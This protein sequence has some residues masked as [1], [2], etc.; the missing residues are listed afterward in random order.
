MSVALADPLIAKYDVPGPR[1]TS[2]PTVPYWDTMPDARQWVE[3]IAE[4]LHAGPAH[5]AA[6]Y[7][8]IPFCRALCT[9]CGCNT[10]ITRSHSIVPPYI[11]ALL[12]ELDLYLKP[13]QLAQLEF[14]E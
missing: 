10:R 9:Y 7:L 14:G 13:L 8:H 4:A 11:Q 12:G 3:R 6:L 1:Y 5:S 2:Y